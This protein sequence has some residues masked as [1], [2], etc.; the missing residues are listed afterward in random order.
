MKAT[1]GR[2]TNGRAAPPTEPTPAERLA[3]VD[4]LIW[5]LAWKR[6]AMFGLRRCEQEAERYYAAGSAAVATATESYDEALGAFT[7]YAHHVALNAMRQSDLEDKML[8][9]CGYGGHGYKSLDD[10]LGDDLDLGDVAHDRRVVQPE[11]GLRWS[12]QQWAS[13]LAILPASERRAVRLYYRDD[14]T[15]REAGK[16]M[17]VSYERVRQLVAA[18]L[19]RLKQHEFIK[20]E[21]SP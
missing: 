17:G 1:N 20:Q 21:A 5:R 6:A 8:G 2:R 9:D 3:S 19:Q 14:L 13:L 11:P 18:A 12:P 16:R 10:A 15:L 7:T 4:R